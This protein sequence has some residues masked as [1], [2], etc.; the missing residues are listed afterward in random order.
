MNIQ[1]HTAHLYHAPLNIVINAKVQNPKYLLFALLKDG[2]FSVH[3]LVGPLVS[4]CRVCTEITVVR[5]AGI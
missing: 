2:I 5:N 1:T 3:I 4:D